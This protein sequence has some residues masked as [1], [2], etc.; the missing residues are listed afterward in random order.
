MDEICNHDSCT[1]CQ[2][3][4][5]ACPV[6]AISMN[7]DIR[8]FIYPNINQ[9][10]CIDCKKCTRVCPNLND[11][12]KHPFNEIVYACWLNDVQ[13]R[14]F[15]TS[16]GLSYAFSKWIVEKGG[17]FCGCEWKSNHAEHSL[18]ECIEDLHKYQ[19]SKY[20]YS[21]IGDSYKRIK[22]HL[23]IQKEVLFIGTPCQVAG[24]K[25]YLQRDYSNLY[26]I[27]ILCHGYTSSKFL[28]DRIKQ[29]VNKHDKQVVDIRFRNKVHGQHNTSMKYIF[30][31]C[32]FYMCSEFK[33]PYIRAFNGNYI[34]RKNCFLCKY[35]TP[36]RVADITLGDFWGYKP[37]KFKHFNHNKGTSLVILNSKKGENMFNE[38][39]QELTIDKRTFHEASPYNTNL[40]YPQRMPS[41][42][43][44]FW[45]DYANCTIEQ[46]EEK[47]LRP[48]PEWKG[49]TI[50]NRIKLLLKIL[51]N[52]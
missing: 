11:V 50:K 24:L 45:K 38:I 23:S 13:N 52:K 26:T 43:E 34:L 2:A 25:S 39:A 48:I 32:S 19:G 4:S 5:N 8:G 7:E 33:D 36:E 15:S 29:V 35:A 30:K 20:T 42:Y 14:E 1:G 31:D 40:L 16:G 47:Y 44:D 12:A 41:N 9:E 28:K 51:L 27:E 22:T 49:Y 17:I 6:K 46:L 10:I 3:C 21:H 18:C 37:H